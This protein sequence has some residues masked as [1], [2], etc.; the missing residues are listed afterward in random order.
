MAAPIRI[1]RDRVAEAIDEGAT[2]REVEA[3]VITPAPLTTD[4]R[5]A[6]W[7]YAW[8]LT[9]EREDALVGAGHRAPR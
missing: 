8:G 5:D 2:L 4:L 6:L 9:E 7:L 1:L 3:E